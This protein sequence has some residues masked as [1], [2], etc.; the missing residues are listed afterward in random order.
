MHC[1]EG[2]ALTDAEVWVDTQERLDEFLS[3]IDSVVAV[4]TEFVRRT[5]FF[6]NRP[7]AARCSGLYRRR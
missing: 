1:A 2:H 7:V 6:Q 4:D 5:T 3:S